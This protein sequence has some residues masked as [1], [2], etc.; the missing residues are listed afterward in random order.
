MLKCKCT[1]VKVSNR[2]KFL[3]FLENKRILS[4]ESEVRHVQKDCR[5]QEWT[6]S[7]CPPAKRSNEYSGDSISSSQ[8]PPGSHGST[9]YT[10]TEVQHS[11]TFPSVPC[12]WVLHWPLAVSRPLIWIRKIFSIVTISEEERSWF[13]FWWVALEGTRQ[14]S[15]QILPL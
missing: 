6:Q 12:L 14:V 4:E 13:K 5:D 10:L 7:D 1:Q 3:A 9:T 2:E 15:V 8:P 11:L